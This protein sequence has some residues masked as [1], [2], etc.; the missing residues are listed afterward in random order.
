MTDDSGYDAYRK[1]QVEARAASASQEKLVVML[2]EGFLDEL[3]RLEGHLGCFNDPTQNSA[4]KS[5]SLEKKGQSIT[6]CINILRGLETSLDMEGGGE[7]AL[8][9]HQLYDYMGRQ[10]NKVSVSNDA[11]EL[12]PVREIMTDLWEGWVAMAA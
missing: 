12:A 2:I 11:S 1:S 9:L 3:S 8:Q 6:R 4:L 10:L 7:L 5:K